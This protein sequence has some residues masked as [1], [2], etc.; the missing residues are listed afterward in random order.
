MNTSACKHCYYGVQSPLSTFEVQCHRYPERTQVTPNHWCGEYKAQLE[1]LPK[2]AANNPAKG[3]LRAKT[4]S[5][6][7]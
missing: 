4:Q 5:A 1:E 2:A 6:A 3:G 7:G